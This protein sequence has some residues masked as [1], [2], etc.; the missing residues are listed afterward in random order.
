MARS[1]SRSAGPTSP[2]IRPRCPRAAPSPCA[3]RRRTARSPW[4]SGAAPAGRCGCRRAKPSPAP[5]ACSPAA[6]PRAPG[7]GASAGPLPIAIDDT[8]AGLLDGRFD[9]RETDRGVELHGERAVTTGTRRL[10]GRATACVGRDRELFSLVEMFSECAGEQSAQAVLVTAPAGI[11]KSRLA[12]EAMA[13]IKAR[14]PEAALWIAR[15]D[16]LRG[17]SAFA[18]L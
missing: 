8:T 9:V 14:D 5:P 12:A 11:G 13:Q 16:P 7:R 18:L 1:R 6:A 15:G 2:P 3:T 4:R 17:G 10:L